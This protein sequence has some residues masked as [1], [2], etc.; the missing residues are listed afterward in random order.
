MQ[1]K[2]VVGVFPEVVPVTAQARKCAL[3]R[4]T[5]Q[6]RLNSQAIREIDVAQATTVVLVLVAMVVVVEMAR[7]HQRFNRRAESKLHLKSL[8]NHHGTLRLH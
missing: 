4:P 3:T 6:V 5:V 1:N 2:R 8:W 7:L